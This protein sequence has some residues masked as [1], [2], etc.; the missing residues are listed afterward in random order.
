M[1]VIFLQA[2]CPEVEV[3]GEL[4]AFVIS[5]EHDDGFRFCY[6]EGEDED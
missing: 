3:R 5:S 2:L 4:P 1:L 6:F